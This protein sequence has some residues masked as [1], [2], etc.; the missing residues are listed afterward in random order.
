MNLNRGINLGGFLSQCVHEEA[1][2]D[3][4]IHEED[5]A[6]IASWGLD[7]VRLPI[8]YEV[9]EDEEGNRKEHGYER[10]MEVVNWAKKNG[11]N[12]IL[13][14]HKAC[15]YSFT[16]TGEEGMNNL[17]DS[18]E[19]QTRFINLWTSISKYFKDCDNVAYELL[20]E[21]VEMENADK[22][23]S[24]VKRTVAAIR[25]FSPVTTIIYGG[26]MWNSVSAI[27]YLEKPADENVLITF[28]FYEPFIFTHQ[29]AHWVDSLDKNKTIN[30]PV[31]MEYYMNESKLVGYQASAILSCKSK[32]MGTEFITEMIQDGIDAAE[33][34][35]VK[36]YCGE[37]GV[38]DQAPIED[39]F[40]WYRDVEEVFEKFNIGCC[41]WTYRQMDFGITDE[42][43][44]E[45]RDRILKL[46]AR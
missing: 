6:T 34:L 14:L 33:K 29:K 32:T 35:G 43:Y 38:I 24:L 30:Y 46:W 5:L 36:L 39:S 19:L 15:G 13:D 28:H 26:I 20:N 27:K 40:N 1:H 25:E 2:Y 17:F 10:V 3:S 41:A 23:N 11:L 18:A 44:A 42:H 7:H 31:N 9:L 4:F 45:Y 8:D 37:F 16:T 21:V 22:W 12:I